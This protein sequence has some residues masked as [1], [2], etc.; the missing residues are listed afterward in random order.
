MQATN[1]KNFRL[2][3][4]AGNVLTASQRAELVVLCNRAYD[5]D[6]EPLLATYTDP[7]HV[8]AY[9]DDK[10]VSHALW[11]TRWLSNDEGPLMRTAFVELVA[12]EPLFE[13]KGF[14]SQVMRRVAAEITG[15]DLGALWPNY[16]EWYG[17]LGWQMWR[18]PLFIR[19][20]DGL[21]STPED[22]VMV[23][24]L[25]QTPALNFE[26]SLSAEWREGELW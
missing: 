3:V 8:L 2:E 18:G 13:G 7:V 21:I 5:E 15:F 1:L 6:V 19:T 4:V 14:A 25:P 24:V 20:D 12:T 10:M 9:L 23:L 26:G 17:R 22:I 16:P 11:C